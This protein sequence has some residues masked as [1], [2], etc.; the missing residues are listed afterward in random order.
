M[1]LLLAIAIPSLPCRAADDAD[2]G[3]SSES[4][5]PGTGQQPSTLADDGDDEKAVTE[6]GDST[7]P[8]PSTP[9]PAVSERQAILD[10]LN[11]EAVEQAEALW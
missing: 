7:S 8:A 9:E 11:C 2:E 3:T 1:P 5:G 6:T 4:S 10:R